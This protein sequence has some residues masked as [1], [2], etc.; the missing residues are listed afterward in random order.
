ML[1]KERVLTALRKEEPDQVPVFATLTPQVAERLGREL[2][3]P[4][5]PEDSFYSPRI[6]HME[7]VVELGSDAVCIGA[8]APLDAP[9]TKRADGRTVDEWG[10]VYEPT[11]LYNEAVER[12]LGWVNDVDDLKK[13]DFPK[14]DA[15][16]RF[17]RA[18]EVVDAYGKDY[19]V[20]GTI[21]ATMF[22]LAWSLTGLEKYLIDLVQDNPYTH[23]LAD[24][25]FEY[26]LECAKQLIALGADIIWTGDDFGTQTGMLISPNLWRKVF[27]PRFRD[28]F[29]ELRRAKSD[30]IIAYHSCGAI[31]PIIE[32][33]IEIGLHVLNPI[34]PQATGMNLAG[35]K[36]KYGDRL[37]FFGG[38]DIQGVLP[39]G[40]VDDVKQE[41]KDRI[42]AAGVGG[43]YLLA[44]AHNIQPDTPTEN[45]RAFFAAAREY[46]RYPLT[47]I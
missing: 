8:Q 41:V 2:G 16:G 17:R 23:K 10:I 43:G 12:P 32:D 4:Y 14:A 26:N 9:S 34:Q 5:Q 40:T 45:V 21:E 38:V 29:S 37:C 15:P 35:L 20:I 42:L 39:R 24:L 11:G 31:S 22:E 46:G 6:S 27:K 18:Q 44:P 47:A 30:I 28:L 3:L 13:Y 1:P 7:I 25:A 19:A 36:E 33:L